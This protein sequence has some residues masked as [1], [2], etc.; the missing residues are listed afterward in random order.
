[1]TQME[2]AEKFAAAAPKLR[3]SEKKEINKLFPAIIFR[4]S[5]TREVWSSCCGVHR[6]LPE[7]TTLQEENIMREPHVPEPV[8]RWYKLTNE[9]ESSRRVKCPWCGEEAKVKELGRTGSRKNLFC[10][11]R[12]VVLRQFRGHLWAKAYDCFK[13]YSINDMLTE[14]PDLTRLP[15]VKLLGVYRFRPGMAE[16]TTRYW[17]C[18]SPFTCL[19]NQTA[20]GKK[21]LWNIHDPYGF[22][23]DLGTSYDVIGWDEIE[24]GDF[25][26]C[27]VPNI[28]AKND[29]IELLTACCFYPRQIEFLAKSSKSTDGTTKELPANIIQNGNLAGNFMLILSDRGSRG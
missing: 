9:M 17:W 24:K 3:A 4:R 26:F 12:A 5:K 14:E 10:Y 1:M 27:G 21:K 16:G 15:S 11:R 23:G 19:N 20:P 7:N 6:V 22:S 2:K 18:S 25:R 8:F 13:D 29:V 28:N